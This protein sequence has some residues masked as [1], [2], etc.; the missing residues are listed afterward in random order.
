MT[1]ICEE[2]TLPETPLKYRYYP[3]S[4]SQRICYNLELMEANLAKIFSNE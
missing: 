3:F 2:K 1:F 4:S